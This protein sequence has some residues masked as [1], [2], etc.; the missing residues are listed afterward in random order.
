MHEAHSDLTAKVTLLE[1]S[2][3]E[4]GEEVVEVRKAV[5]SSSYKI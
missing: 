4:N 1:G 2:L 5:T 3:V